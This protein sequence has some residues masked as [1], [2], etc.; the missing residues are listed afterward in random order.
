MTSDALAD[1]LGENAVPTATHIG[2]SGQRVHNSGTH[3]CRPSNARWRARG[4]P[5]NAIVCKAARVPGKRRSH[6][7]GEAAD[8]DDFLE[9]QSSDLHPDGVCARVCV[10]V[11]VGCQIPVLVITS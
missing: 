11:C 6:V 8:K 5:A 3:P 4:V 1:V 10:R 9:T 2:A 7:Q